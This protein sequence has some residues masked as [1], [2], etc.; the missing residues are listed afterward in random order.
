MKVLKGHESPGEDCGRPHQTVGVIRWFPVWLHPRQSHNRRNICCQAAAR[1]VSSCQQ[2]TLLGFCRPGEGFWSSTLEGHLVGDE[3]TWVLRSGLCDW[4]RGCMQCPEPCL[5]WWGVQWSLKWRSV[6]I[7][8]QYPARFSSLCLKPY[9]ES[10]TLGSMEDLYADDLVIIAESLEECVRRLLTWKEAMEKKGLRVNAGKTIMICGRAWTFCRVQESFHAPS[11]ALEWA[12]TASSAMAAN[13]ACTRN[14]VGSRAWLRT[15]A[16]DGGQT[17]EG[18]P[19]WTWQAG[20]GSFLLLPR[21]HA[22]SSRWL[23]SFNHNTYENSLE[24]VQGAATSSLFTPPLFQ[25][26]WPCVQFLCA[27]RNAPCQ[28]DLAIDKTKPP[29]SATEWQG[30]DQTDLQ[31]QA[32]R[33]F[34]QVHWATC[35]A[36]WESG[37]NSEG[38]KA[39]LVWTCGMLQWCSQDSLSHTC[40]GKAL[41]LERSNGK[42]RTESKCRKDDHDLRYGLDLLQSSGEFPCAVCRTGR[43]KMTWKQLSERD[44]RKWKLS[45]NNPHD[46]NMW[47][48]GVRSAMHAASQLSG[49]KPTDVDVAPVPVR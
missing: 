37:P 41:D 48:S 6:Y 40:W 10:S 30:N 13:I 22:L 8:A 11:V 12:A 33:R 16:T 32:A 14:A 15:L 23:W 9:H 17:T 42:E 3:K 4:C 5:C 2:V 28:W 20:G 25:D 1:E 26:R 7:R 36:Y 21:R 29:T 18:S 35:V 19:S 34:H 43:L 31:C 49:R 47:R 38:E 46:R 44:C 27:E 24:E 39:P 45:A